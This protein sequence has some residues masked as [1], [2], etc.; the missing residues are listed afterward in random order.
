MA[1][2]ESESTYICMDN[3]RI[4]EKTLSVPLGFEGY[5][6][7]NYILNISKFSS[8]KLECIKRRY[9]ALDADMA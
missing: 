9:I 2:H 6:C 5:H 8:M 3:T 4:F 1:I 7:Y